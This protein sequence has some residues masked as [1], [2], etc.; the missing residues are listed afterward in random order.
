MVPQASWTAA[1]AWL[2]SDRASGLVPRYLCVRRP[3]LSSVRT[4]LISALAALHHRAWPAQQCVIAL[5]PSG[6]SNT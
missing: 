1:S 3:H 5:L 4:D 6:A 2:R